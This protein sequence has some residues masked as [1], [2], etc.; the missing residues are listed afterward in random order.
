MCVNEYMLNVCNYILFDKSYDWLSIKKSDYSGV[1]FG[2]DVCDKMISMVNTNRIIA[3][4]KN[5]ISNGMKVVYVVPP[6]RESMLEKHTEFLKSI[7]SYEIVNEIV[8]NDF[9]MLTYIRNVLNWK[10]TISF[11]LLFDKTLRE[12]RFPLD[13]SYYEI[14]QFDNYSISKTLNDLAQNYNV[15]SI[16][17]DTL[18]DKKLSI[19]QIGLEY[20][21]NIWYP[22]VLISKASICEYALNVDDSLLGSYSCNNKC[23]RNGKKTRA[24]K[25]IYKEGTSIF[26]IQ[27]EPLE[28]LI[29]GRCRAVISEELLNYE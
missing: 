6:V 13:C 15:E 10:G 8:I 26:C 16:E 12:P 14:T 27:K 28:D 7:L 23:K 22:R 17:L 25:N 18:I 5:V 29:I 4:M 19:K 2:F 24:Y 9:G 11:G 20:K 21:I 1:Y 3:E